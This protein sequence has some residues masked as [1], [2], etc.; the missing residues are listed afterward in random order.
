MSTGISYPQACHIYAMSTGILYPQARH[1]RKHLAVGLS[2]VH[3]NCYHGPGSTPS[4]SGPMAES[5]LQKNT[6][7]LAPVSW[8]H[9]THTG[10][11]TNHQSTEVLL[12]LS[13]CNPMGEP[14]RWHEPVGSTTSSC[15]AHEGRD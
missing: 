12:R 14:R 10:E 13:P 15:A 5:T 9:R 2:Y 6:I 8:G 7:A 11:D 4:V 1:I 3:V